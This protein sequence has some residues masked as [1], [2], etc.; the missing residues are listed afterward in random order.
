MTNH[1]E[2]ALIHL[3]SLKGLG[4]F[5]VG[6][7]ATV[8]Y[9]RVRG[10]GGPQHGWKNLIPGGR[11]ATLA[12]LWIILILFM[13]G[14]NAQQRYTSS[15]V[16]DLASKTAACQHDMYLALAERAEM[17]DD[18][19]WATMKRDTLILQWMKEASKYPD[20]V[21]P[22]Q[23]SLDVKAKYVPLIEEA[24]AAELETMKHRE[25]A[26]VAKPQCELM[27]RRLVDER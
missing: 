7:V 25:R 3:F 11:S 17:E 15:Q 18:T 24:Q 19:G 6:S 14:L 23:W 5:V 13:A 20:G 1:F 12:V 10:D 27:L 2:L 21:D 4:W 8:G 26:P 22:A 16:K 9:Y